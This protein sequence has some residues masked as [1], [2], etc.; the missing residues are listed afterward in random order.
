MKDHPDPDGNVE[1]TAACKPSVPMKASCTNMDR[2]SGPSPV[3]LQGLVYLHWD[4]WIS[5]SC[6]ETIPKTEH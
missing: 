5:V 6:S 3:L 1:G 4:K 2:L